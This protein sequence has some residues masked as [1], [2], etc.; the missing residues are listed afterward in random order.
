[1]PGHVSVQASETPL[2]PHGTPLYV[3]VAD[4]RCGSCRAVVDSRHAESEVDRRAV[5]RERPADA[6]R[7][8][9]NRACRRGRQRDIFDKS[10]VVADCS[11]QI[12]RRA[13]RKPAEDNR[14]RSIKGR[15]DF[16]RCSDGSEVVRLR[17]LEPDRR[18]FRAS[19]EIRNRH[20]R[21]KRREATLHE[22]RRRGRRTGDEGCEAGRLH[23]RIRAC[24]VA[25]NR[26]LDIIRRPV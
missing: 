2:A 15:R 10:P 7:R 16:V 3:S 14:R 13:R 18:R 9:G 12:V 22:C 5:I 24:G 8:K 1:M 4:Q 26:R 6:G 19:A 25:C 21:R 17:R 11:T 20:G 23:D